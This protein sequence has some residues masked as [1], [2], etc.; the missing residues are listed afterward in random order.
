MF[1]GARLPLLRQLGREATTVTLRVEG[2]ATFQ[3]FPVVRCVP[4]VV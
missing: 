3:E 4:I 2:R 1:F